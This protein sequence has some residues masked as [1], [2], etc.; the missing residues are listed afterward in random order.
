MSTSP[1]AVNQSAERTLRVL[2]VILKHAVNGLT[3]GEIVNA[4]GLNASSVSRYVAALEQMG[5]A[6]RIPETD[7]IR[8][9]VRVAQRAMA[10]LQELDKAQSRLNEL[11][12]RI[13]Q[14][15]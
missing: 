12:N 2:D 5:W 7:R 8:A 9:S 14:T 15:Y 11:R 4:T 10:V 6:E 13:T 1:V 3:P